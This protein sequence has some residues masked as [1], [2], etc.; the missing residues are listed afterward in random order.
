MWQVSL[1]L[2]TNLDSREQKLLTVGGKINKTTDEKDKMTSQQGLQGLI[3]SADSS[4][5]LQ[6]NDS[7]VSFIPVRRDA[8]SYS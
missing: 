6:K 4:S 1:K 5:I 7:T 3:T 2:K 8:T